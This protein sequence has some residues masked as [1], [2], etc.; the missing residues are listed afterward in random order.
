MEL[1]RFKE[2]ATA[3]MTT[4]KKDCK[5]LAAKLRDARARLR[6]IAIDNVDDVN[7][8]DYPLAQLRSTTR[9]RGRAAQPRPTGEMA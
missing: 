7:E 2:I 4:L 9:P 8:V 5:S 6:Q 3:E 1:R